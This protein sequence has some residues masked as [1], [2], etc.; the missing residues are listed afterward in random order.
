M[1]ITI[2]THD[3]EITIDKIC[4]DLESQSELI[5]KIIKVINE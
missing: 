3:T 4:D 1:E 5:Q 2:K